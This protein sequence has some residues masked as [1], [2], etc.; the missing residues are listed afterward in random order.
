[1]VVNIFFSQLNNVNHHFIH[2]Q[3]LQFPF[4]VRGLTSGGLVCIFRR[5]QVCSFFYFAFLGFYHGV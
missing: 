4:N 5:P 1:M 3:H 2:I